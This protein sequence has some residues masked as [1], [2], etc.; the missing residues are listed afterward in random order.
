[1]HRLLMLAPSHYMTSHLTDFN[2]DLR[3]E[4]PP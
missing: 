4:P 1:M 2:A 3:I